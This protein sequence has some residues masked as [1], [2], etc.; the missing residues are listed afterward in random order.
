M[1]KK[2]V[3]K[4]GI[5]N[6]FADEEELKEFRDR[7]SGHNVKGAGRICGKMLSGIDAGSTTTKLA[8]IGE[9]DS[10]LYSYYGSNKGSASTVN[11]LRDLYNKLPQVK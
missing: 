4:V 1:E 10:L 3:K 8:L 11:A 2:I 7:H 5:L 6:P 9:D